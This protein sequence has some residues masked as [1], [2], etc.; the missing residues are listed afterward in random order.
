MELQVPRT[1]TQVRDRT[2]PHD[3]DYPPA[4]VAQIRRDIRK[5]MAKF[6]ASMQRER[7]VVDPGAETTIVQQK[8]PG[9]AAGG[10]GCPT[11]EG[12]D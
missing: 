8:A 7:L 3:P 2:R 12:E 11:D 9:L 4:R 10:S 6:R 5:K 1:R